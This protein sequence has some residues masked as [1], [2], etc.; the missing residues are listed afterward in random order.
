MDRIYQRLLKSPERSFFLFG[1]RGTGKSTW[2]RQ[3]FAQA[4]ALNLDLLDTALQLEL[5]AAPSRLEALIGT[6]PAQSWV[7]LDEVQKIP[8]LMDEV[9]RLIESRGWRFALCG[10]SARKLRRGGADLLAGRAYTLQMEGFCSAE[11]GDHFEVQKVLEWGALPV[12]WR[13]P[14][15]PAEVLSAYWETYL[16]EEIRAESVVRNYPPFVRFLAIAGQLNGQVLNV[17]NIAR[18]AAVSRSAVEGYFSILQDTLL[19]Q[20]LPAYRPGLKVRET[21]HPKFYWNDNGVARVAAGLLRDPLESAWKGFAL[22]ALVFH[23]LRVFNQLSGKHRP[24][25]FYRTAAGVEIDFLI[26]TRKPQ[27][28]S[29]PEVV[30]VE[31][32]FANQWKREWERG[33]RDLATLPGIRVK[34]MVGVY[35]GSR[36]YH[37][38]GVDVLPV[39]EFLQELFAGNVY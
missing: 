26:E 17:Q 2:L 34:R 19:A 29:T 22:E 16:R 11:L 28:G 36:S 32:K 31:V 38:D 1:A 10:S 39:E 24:L 3:Q 9:H 33:M 12:V 30:C 21:A 18:E 27:L 14:D 6:R 20:F 37:F 23:E 25:Y 15:A 4:G 8:L 35:Q 13:A 5:T 7:V